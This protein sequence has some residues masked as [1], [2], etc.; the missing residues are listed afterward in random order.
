[1]WEWDALNGYASELKI[2]FY[3][4]YKNKSIWKTIYEHM[5]LIKIFFKGYFNWSMYL[6]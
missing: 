4:V 5:F 3:P 2:S 6:V 1:M